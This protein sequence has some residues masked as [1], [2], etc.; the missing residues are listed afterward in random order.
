M[1]DYKLA[2]QMKEAG[3]NQTGYGG[4]YDIYE[5]GD[6]SIGRGSYR[7]IGVVET[8]YAPLIEEVIEACGEDF[9]GL[10]KKSGGWLANSRHLIDE[11]SGVV[12]QEEWYGSTPLEAVC[13]LWLALNG[14]KAVDNRG[15]TS[16]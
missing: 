13:K 2:L 7:T 14:G 6:T 5:N 16:R 15:K 8:V 12:H 10:Y 3:F 4:Y 11:V 1:I 9:Y